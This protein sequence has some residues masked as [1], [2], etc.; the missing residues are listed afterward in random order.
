MAKVPTPQEATLLQ[1]IPTLSGTETGKVILVQTDQGLRKI[2]WDYFQNSQE[3]L[4]GTIQAIPYGACLEQGWVPLLGGVLKP[5]WFADQLRIV[6]R[7]FFPW[8]DSGTGYVNLPLLN[9]VLLQFDQKLY[10]FEQQ[11]D[12]LQNIVADFWAGGV[13]QTGDGNIFKSMN[14]WGAQF[15]KG[16][17]GDGRV[18]GVWRMDVSGG[19]GM[20]T[21][22]R[23]RERTVNVV[24]AIY[25]GP[26]ANKGA[27]TKWYALKESFGGDYS[28]K[29]P[30]TTPYSFPYFRLW[31]PAG[32]QDA[33]GYNASIM[34]PVKNDVEDPWTKL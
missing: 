12:A 6:K 32:E 8:V 26:L 4:I 15:R 2:N 34:E 20:R 9:D 10:H 13:H 29:P 3:H 18:T 31:L 7:R 21:A 30:S 23:T 17:G 22:D 33:I 1:D 28:H 14:N 27:V 24:W 19:T 16:S 5:E 25:C 11:N